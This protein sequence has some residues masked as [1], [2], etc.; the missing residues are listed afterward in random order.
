MSLHETLGNEDWLKNNE[1]KVKALFPSA[2]TNIQNLNGLKL[3]SELRLLGV[4]WR[5]EKE[6]EMI[7]VFLEKLGFV[8]RDGKA[9]KR[10]PQRMFN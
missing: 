6:F 3:G 7:M 4:A 5:T 10:N 8:I 2:L 1:D 9:V